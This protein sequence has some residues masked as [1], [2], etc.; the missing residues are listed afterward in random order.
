[1]SEE[2]IDVERMIEYS[3]EK[4]HSLEALANLGYITIEGYEPFR[5]ERGVL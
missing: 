4:G 2:K 1:M 3:I 5:F